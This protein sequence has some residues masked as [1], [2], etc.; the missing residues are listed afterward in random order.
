MRNKYKILCILMSLVFILN[1]PA[2]SA[3]G[4]SNVIAIGVN[5]RTL[6]SD[7]KAEL[8]SDGVIYVPL[9]PVAEALGCGVEWDSAN[10]ATNVLTDN[11]ILSFQIGNGTMYKRIFKKASDVKSI[12]MGAAPK[13]VNGSTYVPAASLIESGLEGEMKL[14]NNSIINIT[15]RV[16]YKLVNNL[17]GD[18]LYVTGT[19]AIPDNTTSNHYSQD[20]FLKNV[21]IPRTKTI[22]ICD[23]ITNV[24]EFAYSDYEY[25]TL[26]RVGNT[27]ENIENYAFIRCYALESLMICDG[28]SSIGN[29]AFRGC[30]KLKY[31]TIPDTMSYIAF[32]AFDGCNNIISVYCSEETAERLPV[33]KQLLANKNCKRYPLDDVKEFVY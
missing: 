12:A 2:F 14:L 3:Y 33:V 1:I 8:T 5:G 7:A 10:K 22:Y 32:D 24:G 4:G 13:I 9:K 15:C 20:T 16:H 19:G 25:A 28:V 29:G 11:I 18:T 31:V 21:T 23:G 30:S 26:I 6:S 17:K 27:V